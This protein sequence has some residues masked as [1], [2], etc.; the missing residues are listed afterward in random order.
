MLKGAA[1]R[2]LGGCGRVGHV[3]PFPVGSFFRLS[4]Q[5]DS[6]IANFEVV[7]NLCPWLD[8]NRHT[9]SCEDKTHPSGCRAQDYF[10]RFI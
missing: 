5:D 4:S 2:W 9:L 10:S 6:I 7:C 1:A 3:D 8:S